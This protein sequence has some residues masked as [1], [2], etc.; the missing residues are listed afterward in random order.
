[1]L[2]RIVRQGAAGVRHQPGKPAQVVGEERHVGGLNGG[3]AAGH[4]HGD[5][6]GGPGHGGGVVDPVADHGHAAVPPI[7]FLDRGHLVGR[8]EIGP[9]LGQA[10]RPRDRLGGAA[11]VAGQQHHRSAAEALEPGHGRCRFRPQPVER[12]QE[13]ADVPLVADHRHR[14]AVAGERLELLVHPGRLLPPFLEVEVRAEP[15]GAPL[16]RAVHPLAR[17]DLV[18]AGGHRHDPPEA[19]V[20]HDGPGHRVIAGGLQ[21]RR[22]GQQLLL[23]VAVQRHDLRP[24]PGVPR[25]GCRSCRRRRP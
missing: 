12:R 9:H 21:R 17:D 1:M 16:E 10:A 23:G 8:P 5:A 22:A 20:L 11:V 24:S 13:A 4:P 25:S 15:V 3:V 19:G 6:E 2:V 7:E 18:I 14:M